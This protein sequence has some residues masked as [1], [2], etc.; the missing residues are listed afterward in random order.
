VEQPAET[1]R[2]GAGILQQ[3]EVSLIVEPVAV[4][5]RF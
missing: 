2:N 4:P 1:A 5:V 3:S